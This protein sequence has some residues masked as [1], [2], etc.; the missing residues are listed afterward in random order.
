[1]Q[2]QVRAI[3]SPI[4]PSAWAAVV[5]DDGPTQDAV[6]LWDLNA[7]KSKASASFPHE[8]GAAPVYAVAPMAQC[9][10]ESFSSRSSASES[11]Q[12]RKTARRE[13]IVLNDALGTPTLL[14]FLN[15][16]KVAVIWHK[17]E[18]EGMQ[19][20]DSVSGQVARQVPFQRF[21]RSANN[22]VVN[23][24]GREFAYTSAQI[25]RGSPQVALFNLYAPPSAKWRW[26]EILDVDT[27]DVNAPAGLAYSQD[28]KKL[29][30]LFAKQGAGFII[31]W[32]IADVKPLGEYEVAVPAAGG[33]GTRTRVGRKWQGLADHGQ[34]TGGRQ[35]WKN[36]RTTQCAADDSSVD[37]RA[38]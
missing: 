38:G 17:G 28:G 30:A 29:A 20:F 19:I 33:A 24:D 25:P 1:M 22:G 10:R 27:A 8:V 36:A 13:R 34:H 35:R 32:R 9:S 26:H 31:C 37:D 23:P 12:P 3:V 21:T 6:E 18:D 4:I 5:R 16:E 11:G 2:D 14:G 7:G 15:P